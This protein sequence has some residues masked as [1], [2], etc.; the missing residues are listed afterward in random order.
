MGIVWI[1]RDKDV[2]RSGDRN[3]CAQVTYTI[4][5]EMDIK[6]CGKKI[7]CHINMYI[8][9]YIYRYRFV[10]IYIYKTQKYRRTQ[11]IS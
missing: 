9:T 5:Y 4:I 1:R 6:R 2:M 8:D 10:D 7:I 11:Y 3:Q